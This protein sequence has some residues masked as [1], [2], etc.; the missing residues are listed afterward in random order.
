MSLF[1]FICII[2]FTVG[3]CIGSFLNVV[4]LRGL[5]GES[6]VFPNSKCPLCKEPIKWYDN[7][8]IL[9][10]IILRGKCRNCKGKISIQYPIIEALTAILFLTIFLFFGF[11]L[12]TLL[13]WI[14]ICI[15]EVICITDI[16]EHV[17][18]SV[19]LWILIFVSLIT[20]FVLYGFKSYL[21]ILL[22]GLCG[23]LVME[24]LYGKILYFISQIP[25]KINHFITSKFNKKETGKPEETNS[26]AVASMENTESQNNEEEIDEY[27]YAEKYKRASGSADTY[28][29][30][31][32][33]LLLGWFF[34]IFAILFAFIAYAI[35]FVLPMYIK[36]LFCMKKYKLLTL[37]LGVIGLFVL[38]K[39]S[40]FGL[41]HLN[42]IINSILFYTTIIGSL[43]Y[44]YIMLSNKSCRDLNFTVPMGPALL[45]SMFIIMFLGNPIANVIIKSFVY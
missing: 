45:I 23:F 11:S 21:F 15:S 18:L 41:I 27:E 35:I 30:V 42:P 4:A 19:H 37:L 2:I 10:Y 14:L 40:N 5:S 25:L 38:L 29:A 31:A 36:N 26:E 3:A 17:A 24:I 43:C 39:C 9:S 32:M 8:P 7:I 16:K 22:G 33:G 44:L 12:K 6:V 34:V 20:S 13:F 1:I 28:I